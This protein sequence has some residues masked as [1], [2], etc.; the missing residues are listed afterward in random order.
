MARVRLAEQQ[1]SC[2]QEQLVG[3]WR[4]QL[5]YLLQ[6]ALVICSAT[7]LDASELLQ[8]QA[9]VVNGVEVIRVLNACGR[10]AFGSKVELARP[11]VLHLPTGDRTKDTP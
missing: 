10:V 11:W 2:R 8:H 5:R 9:V 7:A 1:Q 6:Q 4:I 3:E